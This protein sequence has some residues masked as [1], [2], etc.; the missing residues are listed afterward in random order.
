MRQGGNKHA[1]QMEAKPQ[2][3][4]VRQ[5]SKTSDKLCGFLL[6]HLVQKPVRLRRLLGGT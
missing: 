6:I 2:S 4:Q 1:S 3:W 5:L